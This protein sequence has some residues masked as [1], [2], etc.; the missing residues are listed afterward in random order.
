MKNPIYYNQK[1]ELPSV[2]KNNVNLSDYY[3]SMPIELAKSIE[4]K[5]FAGIANEIKFG[6]ATNG[7][8]RLY[9]PPDSNVNLFLNTWTAGTT[10]SAPFRIQV[11]FNSNPSG[12]IED[13]SFVTVTNTS[14]VP[15]PI[16]K[17]RLQYASGVRGFPEGGSYAFSRNGIPNETIVSEESGKFIFPPGG[18]FLINLSNPATPTQP[19]FGKVAFG[20]WEEPII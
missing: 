17:V 13:S 6:E 3:V 9:N 1:S 20:W 18:S 7:W 8:A 4:G 19:A 14:I 10:T 5:Y 15:A 11:W 16:P 2:F 12:I